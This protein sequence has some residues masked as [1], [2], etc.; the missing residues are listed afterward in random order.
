MKIQ[1]LSEDTTTSLNN[2]CFAANSLSNEKE[3][4]K[5]HIFLGIAN[6]RK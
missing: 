2:E 4:D 6:R 3:I 5:N 1:F